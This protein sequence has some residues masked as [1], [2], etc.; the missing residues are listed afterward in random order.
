MDIEK[1]NIITKKLKNIKTNINDNN[2]NI[3][4]YKNQI[5]NL[6]K[7]INNTLKNNIELFNKEKNIYRNCIKKVI[8]YILEQKK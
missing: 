5:F 6:R 2:S 3:E 1:I 4:K 8:I 7:L